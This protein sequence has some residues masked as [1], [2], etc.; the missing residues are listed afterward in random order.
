MNEIEENSSQEVKTGKEIIIDY[1]T[2]SHEF[3]CNDN[4]V[5]FQVVEDTVEFFRQLLNVPKEL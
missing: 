3:L 1:L 5:E 4:E 2:E